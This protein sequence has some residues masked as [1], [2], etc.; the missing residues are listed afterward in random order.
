MADSTQVIAVTAQVSV[1]EAEDALAAV[2]GL[3]G[4]H[5]AAVVVRRAD[6]RLELHQTEEL[7]VGEGAV[8]GG[9]AGLVAGA[10]LGLPV[11]GALAGILAGGGWGL[12]DAGV[13]NAQLRR[14]GDDL[15]PGRAVLCVLV[16]RAWLPR[17][18]VPLTL[19]GEVFETEVEAA[20]P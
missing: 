3:D 17:V 20:A 2:R 7:A 18:R 9:A 10:L 12:R 1:E 19:Y 6:G 16:D 15:E 13:P 4:V 5:D 8:T 11:V 14:L